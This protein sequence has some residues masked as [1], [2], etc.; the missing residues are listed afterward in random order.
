M[1]SRRV[2]HLPLAR[3]APRQALGTGF[4]QRNGPLG[5]AGDPATVTVTNPSSS[6]PM[7]VAS[8]AGT[9][10]PTWTSRSC[11]QISRSCM[12]PPHGRRSLVGREGVEDGSDQHLADSELPVNRISG[13]SDLLSHSG[14]DLAVENSGFTVA[15]SLD[16]AAGTDMRAPGGAVSTVTL[17]LCGSW[18]HDGPC[19]WP[20]N[21]HLDTTGTHAQ[22]RTVVAAS[23]SGQATIVG[24][25]EDALRGLKEWSVVSIAVEPVREDELPLLGRLISSG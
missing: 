10:T 14:H 16:L 4:G 7:I 12:R 8:T 24:R 18:V 3:Q 13:G 20:H 5:S 15:A 22:L 21:S 11:R 6:S 17:A 1:S 23:E 2:V 9:R 25:I 19:R